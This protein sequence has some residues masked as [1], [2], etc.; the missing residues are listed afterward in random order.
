[1]KVPQESL[2]EHPDHS[3]SLLSH[4]DWTSAYETQAN[5]YLW[6][7][8]VPST[9]LES[10]Q[11]SHSHGL[12]HTAPAHPS[13]LH[14]GSIQQLSGHHGAD[15]RG[16]ESKILS[17]VQRAWKKA[18]VSARIASNPS[19]GQLSSSWPHEHHG[20]STYHRVHV[21]IR[22]IREHIIDALRY[23]VAAF[24]CAPS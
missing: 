11:S 16:I 1:M 24:V 22:P 18:G 17:E 2:N 21:K 3:G 12:C 8:T 5:F 10:S 9:K 15:P 19:G 6:I 4:A 13:G 20:H 23:G 7:S 14:N